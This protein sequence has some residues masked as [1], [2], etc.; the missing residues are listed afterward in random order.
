MRTGTGRLARTAVPLAVVAVMA[1]ACANGSPRETAGAGEVRHVGASWADGYPSVAE[2][3]THADLVVEAVIEGIASTGTFTSDS[4]DASG[5]VPYSDFH[6]TVVTRLKGQSEGTVTIR[7]TGGRT[8]QGS[9]LVV[10]GDPLLD[11]GERAMLFLKRSPSGTYFIMGGPAGRFDISAAGIVTG[12]PGG[13]VQDW[14]S[15]SRAVF[16][17]AVQTAAG[18]R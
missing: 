18:Q 14:S 10:E 8:A 2:M 9:L 1:S 4:V 15:G 13:S 11:A 5:S 6:A 16:D 12:L 3:T 17:R 7:Q